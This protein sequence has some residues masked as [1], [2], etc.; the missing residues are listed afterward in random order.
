META[1]GFS[2]KWTVFVVNRAVKYV[3]PVLYLPH[4]LC[5]ASFSFFNTS[6]YFVFNFIVYYVVCLVK[7]RAISRCCS[8]NTQFSYMAW[9]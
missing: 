3:K 7:E 1:G 9:P 4:L 2:T 5:G 8:A 6:S